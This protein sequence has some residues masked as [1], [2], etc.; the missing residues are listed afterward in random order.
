M[1]FCKKKGKIDFS[2]EKKIKGEKKCEKNLFF[3]IKKG[4]T[5]GFSSSIKKG[6]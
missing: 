1:K 2:M 4:A 6:K 3:P 5:K